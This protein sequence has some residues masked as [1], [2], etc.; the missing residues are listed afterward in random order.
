MDMLDE[1]YSALE[2]EDETLQSL[3]LNPWPHSRLDEIRDYL[4]DR[5]GCHSIIAVGEGDGL[6]KAFHAHIL[7]L[8]GKIGIDHRRR[9][10]R[11]YFKSLSEKGSKGGFHPMKLIQVKKEIQMVYLFKDICR[12]HLDHKLPCISWV[13]RSIK[14]LPNHRL[15]KKYGDRYRELEELNKTL[16][17]KDKLTGYCLYVLSC[18][19]PTFLDKCWRGAEKE[20]FG[21]LVR[22]LLEYWQKNNINFRT[23]SSVD[24]YI[25]YFLSEHVDYLYKD[26]MVDMLLR[27]YTSQLV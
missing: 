7:L 5:F 25:N 2:L 6:K 14:N 16:R 20:L 13:G 23:S 3:H 21:L 8:G 22:R 4:K 26:Q 19:S 24:R 18:K 9:V 12:L 15:Y 11:D 17:K 27:R 1:F 10:I